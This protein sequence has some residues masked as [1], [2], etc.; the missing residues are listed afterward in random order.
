MSVILSKNISGRY[1]LSL[2]EQGLEDAGVLYNDVVNIFSVLER[3]KTLTSNTKHNE[4]TFEMVK[5]GVSSVET[6]ARNLKNGSYEPISD[7]YG[8]YGHFIERYISEASDKA[9]KDPVL[10]VLRTNDV[11]AVCLFAKFKMNEVNKALLYRDV[12]GTK[13]NIIF[14]L[15]LLGALRK[16]PRVPTNRPLYF[17]VPEKVFA[18]K[19]VGVTYSW[20]SF[21][22]ASWEDPLQAKVAQG[23][24]AVMVTGDFIGYDLSGLF[25]DD[26]MK[27]SVVLEPESHYKI[28]PKD[29]RAEHIRVCAEPFD[30][31]VPEIVQMFQVCAE[32]SGLSVR[33][34]EL[35]PGTEQCPVYTSVSPDFYKTTAESLRTVTPLLH[36]KIVKKFNSTIMNDKDAL[37]FM[38]TNNIT[39]DEALAV[40]AFTYGV[41]QNEMPGYKVNKCLCEHNQKELFVYRGYIL[42]LI[43]ALEKI[44][45]PIDVPCELYRSVVMDVDEIE[46]KYKVG[47]VYVWSGFTSTFTTSELAK[48]FGGNVIFIIRAT[49]HTGHYIEPLS[50]FK[51]KEKGT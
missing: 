17:V 51:G 4:P 38:K 33:T 15:L 36:E 49:F 29:S 30:L 22:T 8:N 45:G 31:I 47:S 10:R 7:F 21:V 40:Y 37:N 20:P 43:S 3:F 50:A 46:R 18:N 42:N 16:L 1:L 9:Q 2:G 12:N 19:E 39:S 34:K 41:T 44:A 32:A 5:V 13:N 26:D 27:W 25:S 6:L 14:I 28:I 48:K 11:A 23:N 24:V 35:L